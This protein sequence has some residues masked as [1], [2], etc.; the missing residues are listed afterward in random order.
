MHKIM[1]STT[2]NAEKV[3][4]AARA[5]EQEELNGGGNSLG[6]QRCKH[7]TLA[8]AVVA[9]AC[10]FDDDLHGNSKEEKE[11]HNK[12]GNATHN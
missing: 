1:P 10:H 9:F 12:V 3:S 6:H 11:M 2:T 4:P 7:E 5:F 8:V